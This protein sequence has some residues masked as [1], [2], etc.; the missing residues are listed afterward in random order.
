[1][2]I[3]AHGARAA[4]QTTET[5]AMMKTMRMVE[6]VPNEIMLRVFGLLS[7][8]GIKFVYSS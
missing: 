8:R 7:I 2:R 5:R 1:M 6:S 4:V 3:A